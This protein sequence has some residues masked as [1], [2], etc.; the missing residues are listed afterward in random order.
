MFQQFYLEECGHTLSYVGFLYAIAGLCFAMFAKQFVRLE[1][2][3]G[4]RR[5]TLVGLFTGV[6]I[7]LALGMGGGILAPLLVLLFQA[8]RSYF[9]ILLS[10]TMIKVSSQANGASINCLAGIAF[11]IS[12]IAIALPLSRLAD[13]H[14]IGASLLVAS[15]LALVLVIAAILTLPSALIKRVEMRT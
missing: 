7:L 8:P 13:Q 3:L 6:L 12:F 9:E 4:F 15:R 10:G 1:V 2:T 5:V 11:R 14:T